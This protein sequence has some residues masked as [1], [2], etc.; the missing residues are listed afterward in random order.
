MEEAD[1]VGRQRPHEAEYLSRKENLE[2]PIRPPSREQMQLLLGSMPN[3]GRHLRQRLIDIG[4]EIDDDLMLFVEG[5]TGWML[6]R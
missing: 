1:E 2:T 4:M 5:N 3:A 6:G